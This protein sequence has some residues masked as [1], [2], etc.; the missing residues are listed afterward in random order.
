MTTGRQP[1]EKDF[2]RI[3]EWIKKKKK[4][5]DRPK[6]KTAE[7]KHLA[8]HRIKINNYE[9]KKTFYWSTDNNIN[10][11]N[12]FRAGSKYYWNNFRYEYLQR[13]L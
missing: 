1:S 12:Q 6:K 5:T 10:I 13:Q 8:Q 9:N 11:H 2:L 4:S 3:S 7:K